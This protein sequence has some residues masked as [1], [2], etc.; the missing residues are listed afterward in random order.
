MMDILPEKYYD[1]EKPLSLQIMKGLADLSAKLPSNLELARKLLIDSINDRQMRKPDIGKK[2]SYSIYLQRCD[3]IEAINK[4]QKNPAAVPTQARKTKTSKKA[5][6]KKRKRKDSPCSDPSAA[7]YLI[8]G[9]SQQ[10]QPDE[11]QGLIQQNSTNKRP[12]WRKPNQWFRTD[13]QQAI[14]PLVPGNEMF[15]QGL[16]D[17]PHILTTGI[18]GDN[19]PIEG[20]TVQEFP[21]A[22]PSQLD[23][24]T[25]EASGSHWDDSGSSLQK[26]D[27]ITELVSEKDMPV[28]QSQSIQDLSKTDHSEVLEPDEVVGGSTTL[29]R[30]LHI[31]LDG[32][33]TL[34]NSPLPMPIRPSATTDAPTSILTKD[35]AMDGI[36]SPGSLPRK[37]PII[38][39]PSS[40]LQSPHMKSPGET[41]ESL[42]AILDLEERVSTA[43]ASLEPKSF[44]SSELISLMLERCAP[45]DCFVLDPLYNDPKFKSTFAPRSRKSLDKSISK[46]VVPLHHRNCAHWTVAVFRRQDSAM[47]HLNSLPIPECKVGVDTFTQCMRSIDPSYPGKDIRPGEC[48]V[49]PNGFD[50]GVHV[51]ANSLYFMAGLQAPSTHNGESWRRLCRAMISRKV[52]NEVSSAHTASTSSGLTLLSQ[53][54]SPHG[55]PEERHREIQQ[56]IKMLE[57]E[58]QQAAKGLEEVGPICELLDNLIKSNK[59]ELLGLNADMT[60]LTRRMEILPIQIR[61]AES[62]SDS[63][64]A[65]YSLPNPVLLSKQKELASYK[66]CSAKVQRRLQRI[67]QQA[68]GLEASR[69]TMEGVKKMYEKQTTTFEAEKETLERALEEYHRLTGEH[70]RAAQ[71]ELQAAHARY[72]AATAEAERASKALGFWVSLRKE[73]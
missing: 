12:S 57:T 17:H 1:P 5:N 36:T 2:K 67:R 28:S 27:T 48:P 13:N 49:Q 6:G 47:Y 51:I 54:V 58:S 42:A 59:Q 29:P 71:E 38:S 64:L 39:L 7:S 15:D 70:C 37:T 56:K 41:S 18:E 45:T 31:D 46:V 16:L 50:C 73:V 14:P 30:S 63:L 65:R 66:S 4:A 22:H 69:Q 34:L 72:D 21:R 61:A 35:S 9:K 33:L 43:L 10:E 68:E 52:G 53:L 62:V 26:N 3:T 11:A 24:T 23:G 8:Q 55:D 20:L 44:L 25:G 60:E 19:V 40:P 32:D